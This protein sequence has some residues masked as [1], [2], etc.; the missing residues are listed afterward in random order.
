LSLLS[1]AGGH[2]TSRKAPDDRKNLDRHIQHIE[3]EVA[4]L[5]PAASGKPSPDTGIA[6]LRRGR[7]KND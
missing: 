1:Q 7:A 6:M 5:K 2:S 3:R 4:D